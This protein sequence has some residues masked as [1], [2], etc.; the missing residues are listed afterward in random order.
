M[1]LQ[2]DAENSDKTDSIYTYDRDLIYG[3]DGKDEIMNMLYLLDGHEN[4]HKIV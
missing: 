2:L 3:N 1:A 4:V